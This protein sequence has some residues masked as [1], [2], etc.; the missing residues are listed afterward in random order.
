MGSHHVG[1]EAG[2]DTG[3]PWATEQDGGWDKLSGWISPAFIGPYN[4]S[5]AIIKFRTKDKAGTNPLDHH[6]EP[7]DNQH[8]VLGSASG[9]WKEIHSQ[10]HFLYG[11]LRLLVAGD[12]NPKTQL[13]LSML[14]FGPGGS[15]ALDTWLSRIG[16]GAFEVKNDLVPTADNAGKI[17][18]SNKRWSE[19]H[20]LQI[21]GGNLF[22]DTDNT[23]DL[24]ENTTPKRWRDLYLAG[25]L[26][27]LG[28]VAVDLIPDTNA[29]RSLG[30]TSKHWYTLYCESCHASDY[31]H[32][33]SGAKLL[34]EGEVR[35]PLINDGSGAYDLGSAAA[36]WSNLYVSGVGDLGWLN[37]GGY[38]VITNARVLQNVTA[39]ANIITAGR[40][41]L[42][43]LPEGSLGYVLEAE[44]GG[45]DPM[46]VDPN[47]RY[48]PK[49]HAHSAHTGI[50]PDDHHARDHNHA[51]ENLSPNQVNCNTMSI[52]SS[53]NRQYSHPSSQQCVYAASVAWEN[54]PHFGCKN[55]S[56]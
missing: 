13:D 25:A 40:L 49:S 43:R 39:N 23:Y 28:N 42:A 10:Y 4:D 38:T 20:A 32:V 36:K 45:F 47:G 11:Y 22:P 12:A 5:P 19:M 29:I 56:P 21:Y 37:V 9:Q 27:A 2:S 50:G 35:G 1:H 17:G 34:M 41:G 52:A 46:Y 30:S 53:C 26:K 14:Q 8:G 3:D 33:M 31:L 7:S 24:G 18:Y 48:T 6:F 54:C 16:A 55:Y 51:G 15:S 44:G